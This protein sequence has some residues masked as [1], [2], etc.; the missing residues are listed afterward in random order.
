MSAVLLTH[1]VESADVRVVQAGNR[2][3]FALEAFTSLGVFG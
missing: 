3:G 1:I 2:S